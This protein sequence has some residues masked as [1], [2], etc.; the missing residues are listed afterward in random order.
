MIYT[1][2]KVTVTEHTA[3]IDRP[4]VLYRGDKNVE[5]Q[6]EIIDSLYK[7]YKFD[8]PNIITNLGASYGQ[9]VIQ[10]PDYTYIISEITQSRDGIV[11]FTIPPEMVDE[12]IEIG[13]YDF[14][15][16]LYDETQES[17]VTLPPIVKGITLKEPIA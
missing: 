7:Q 11:I 16:R 17:R 15:I 8:G 10:K 12:E 6:F 2:V 1:R 13:N 9:L 3:S 5:V 14:Q 4:I